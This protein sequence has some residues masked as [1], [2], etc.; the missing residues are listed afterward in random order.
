MGFLARSLLSVSAGA[1]AMILG[2]E[3][4]LSLIAIAGAVFLLAGIGA[5]IV[6]ATRLPPGGGGSFGSG[7]KG[8]LR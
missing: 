7:F 3:Y 4:N 2:M 6:Y 8:F 1:I 5:L